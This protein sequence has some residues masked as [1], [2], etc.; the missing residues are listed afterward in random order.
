MNAH[1]PGPLPNPNVVQCSK[2][3]WSTAIPVP[4]VGEP[5]SAMYVKLCTTLAN[6]LQTKHK[7][8]AGEIIAQQTMASLDYSAILILGQFNSL[9]EDLARYRDAGRHRLHD[10]TRKARVSDATIEEQVAVLALDPEKQQGVI[11]LFKEMRDAL[12]E[13]GLYPEDQAE[14]AQSPLVVV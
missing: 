11:R 14:A 9:N 12:E 4:I 2:C 1:D 13:R 6:H 10:W 7:K 5:P 3:E 8:V